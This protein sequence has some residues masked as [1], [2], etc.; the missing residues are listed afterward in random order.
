MIVQDLPEIVAAGEATLPDELGG[1]VKFMAHDFFTPQPV[2]ANIYMLRFV[3]HNWPDKYAV[4][5][6]RNLL[7]TLKKEGKILIMD[8]VSLP[9]KQLPLLQEKMVR[10][11]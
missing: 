7:P 10:Y 11:V 2:E 8:A 9:P 3:L 1:Q 6:L 4:R 5:I